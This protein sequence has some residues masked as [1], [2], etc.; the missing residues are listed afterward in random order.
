MKSCS[1]CPN[2]IT[3]PS[4]VTH[5]ILKAGGLAADAFIC[6]D[7]L[8]ALKAWVLQRGALKQAWIEE[9]MGG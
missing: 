2:M 7:C 4:K 6:S 8:N 1:W 9:L 3:D 5:L